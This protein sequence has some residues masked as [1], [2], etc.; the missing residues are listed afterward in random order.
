[1]LFRSVPVHHTLLMVAASYPITWTITS[2][3]IW[4]YYRF[5]HW[6]EPREKTVQ[7]A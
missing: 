6:L 2:A 7:K 1:M 5:G 4:I 3:A